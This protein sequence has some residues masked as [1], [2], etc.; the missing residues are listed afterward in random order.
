MFSLSQFSL[1]RFSLGAGGVVLRF[2]GSFS[3]ELK[4]VSGAAVPVPVSAFM[5]ASI[6][7]EVTGTIAVP[8]AFSAD[9]NM[10]AD[11]K[12]NANIT[13][14]VHFWESVSGVTTGVRNES[15]SGLWSDALNAESWAGKT[16]PFSVGMFDQMRAGA[17][18]SK[19][20]LSSMFVS[21]VATTSASAGTQSTERVTVSITIPPGGELRIDSD[22]YR[23]LLDGANA[24]YAQ[25]G[26]WIKLAREAMYLDIETASGGP[27]EGHMTYQERYL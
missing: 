21:E 19:N 24:L 22:T 15:I 12:A 26:D 7:A 17:F 6:Q 23:V 14:P 27:L 9:A 2:N 10:Q 8:S 18:A 25:E 5:P 1:S 3:E 20:I 11:V 4:S 13:I 16:M